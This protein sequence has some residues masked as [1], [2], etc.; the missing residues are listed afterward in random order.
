MDEAAGTILVVEDDPSMR[1]A[2]VELLEGEGYTVRCAA[3]GRQALEVLGR[4]GP[5]TLI[6]LDLM[7]PVMDGWQFLAERRRLEDPGLHRTPVVLLSGLGFIRG[8][9]G[10]A[11]FLRKPIDAAALIGCVRRFAGASARQP[12]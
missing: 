2:V 8:A 4:I 3:N 12:A 11:D 10:V 9:P 6:L 1:D 5:P 7:M